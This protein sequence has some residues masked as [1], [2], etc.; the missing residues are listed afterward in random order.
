MP[1]P[2]NA[3]SPAGRTVLVD[4]ITGNDISAKDPLPTAG[5]AASGTTD[6]GNPVKVGGVYNST[7]P[8]YTNG[9]RGD[10]Q[11][12][13]RGSLRVEIMDPSGTSS[14]AVSAGAGDATTN[15]GTKLYTQTFGMVFNGTT[16][17]RQKKPNS[18]ARL[19]SSA[20][21]TNATSVKA[22]AGDV[23]KIIGNNTVASKRYLK[24][25]NKASAPNVGTDTPVMTLPLLASAAFEFSFSSL[26]FSTGIAYAITGAAADADTTAV[27]SGDIECLSIVY[28]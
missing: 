4:P 9:Q 13:A 3:G 15:A 11:L 12:G 2:Y 26:Y 17:D 8:T 24:L 6:S 1:G 23:F 22:F 18:I 25:Y 5:N 14:A 27:S 28:A 21:T 7:L 10:V 19:L 16:W 20:A